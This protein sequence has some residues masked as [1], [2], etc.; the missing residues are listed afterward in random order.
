MDEIKDKISALKI[1]KGFAG[2]PVLLHLSGVTD[3]VAISSYFYRIIDI[4]D[5]LIL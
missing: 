4:S 1:P 3:S 2:V 5:F